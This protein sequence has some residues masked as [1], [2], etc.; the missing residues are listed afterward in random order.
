MKPKTYDPANHTSWDD[1]QMG[2]FN[3]MSI[4]SEAKKAKCWI[5]S[6]LTK[7][8][9]TPEE[10]ELEYQ[11]KVSTNKD[12]RLTY[13]NLIIRDPK[14]GIAAYHKALEIELSK[15]ESATKDLRAKAEEF[16]KKV[17]QYYQSMI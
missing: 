16:N 2:R 4:V 6:K 3:D 17:I 10:F 12:I 11:A 15:M 1:K 9:Y 13:Q 7:R 8:W 14:A 5:Y